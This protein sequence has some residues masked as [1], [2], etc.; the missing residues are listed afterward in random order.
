MSKKDILHFRVS[1]LG[2]NLPFLIEKQ[3]SMCYVYLT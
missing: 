2:Y 3:K 1:F